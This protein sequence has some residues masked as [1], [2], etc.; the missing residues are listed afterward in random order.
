MLLLT[1]TVFGY[2][3]E[4]DLS[5]TTVSDFVSELMNAHANH[6]SNNN[7]I[8]QV[9]KKVQEQLSAVAG[10]NSI[11]RV[12]YDEH[13]QEEE[14]ASRPKTSPKLKRR[15]IL[16][17]YSRRLQN[18]SDSFPELMTNAY[19]NASQHRFTTELPIFPNAASVTGRMWKT[20]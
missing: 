3:Q 1:L 9:W 4:T 11:S 20:C 5:T 6:E 16:D 18:V 15:E 19:G 17:Y 2:C 10:K 14:T 8:G 7:M 12:Q 13:S